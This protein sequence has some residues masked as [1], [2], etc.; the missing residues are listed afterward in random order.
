LIRL[1]V[2]DACAKLP[3]K[4]TDV[5]EV[6]SK[7]MLIG[8]NDGR[9]EIPSDDLYESLAEQLGK[10]NEVARIRFEMTW[11]RPQSTSDCLEIILDYVKRIASR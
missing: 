7:V 6:V 1:L 8:L 3:I 11:K 4:K 9:R 2:R 10:L 5:D